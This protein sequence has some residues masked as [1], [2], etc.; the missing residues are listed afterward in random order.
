MSSLAPVN[1]KQ[2]L[3]G[4]IVLIS[5]G[6]LF[7]PMILKDRSDYPA[8]K[9]NQRQVDI[10]LRPTQISKLEQEV[11]NKADARLKASSSQAPANPKSTLS[12]APPMPALPKAQSRPLDENNRKQLA[13]KQ[14]QHALQK[15]LANVEKSKPKPVVVPKDKKISDAYALQLGSFSSQANALGLRRKLR[16]QQF[17]AYIEIIKTSKGI[18]HR[19]R[20][21]PYFKYDQILSVQKKVKTQFKINGKI[22]SYR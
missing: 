9:A 15:Q 22:V 2:R 14:R 5:L 8:P 4:A 6:V 1:I 11:Q 7:L 12:K 18:S 16:A 19:V 17:H 10:P 13:E 20:I 3:V 21:G